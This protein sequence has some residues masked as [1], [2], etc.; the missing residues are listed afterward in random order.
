MTD[1]FVVPRRAIAVYRSLAAAGIRSAIGGALALAYHV[2][3][4]RAT[5]DID[6]NIALPKERASE[7]LEALPVGPVR[8]ADDLAHILR[9]GQVRLFWPLDDGTRLPLDLFFA[10]HQ[11]HH[12]VADRTIMVPMLD[13]EVPIITATDL[14]VFKARHDRGK[15]WVDIEEIVTYAPPSFDVDEA[16]HWLG[17]I[18][19][20]TDSR[21]ARLRDLAQSR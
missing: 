21:I 8:T 17:V 4:P 11:F 2:E 12:V 20:P 19:G 9:D 18:V 1:G 14:V 6:L 10:E 5:R 3:D 7:A 15:D 16:V 13:T